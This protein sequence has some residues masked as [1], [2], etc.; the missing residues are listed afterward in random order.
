MIN[1]LQEK[2]QL[3]LLLLLGSVATLGILPFVVIRYL[4]GNTLASML[5]MMLI[6]GISALVAYAYRFKKIRIVSAIIALFINAGLLVV[7][8]AN[9]V[10]SFFWIYP[11]FAST[12][13]LVKPIEALSINIIASIVLMAFSDVFNSISL[14]S[15]I[16]TIVMLS[17]STFVYASH[18]EKQF[19]LLEALN[20]ID[21][22]TGALNRR[23][24][25]SDIKIALASAEHNGTEQFLAILDLDYFKAVNDTYGHAVGDQVLQDFVT[26]T[27]TNIRK[28]DRLYRLGGEE[29][30]LLVSTAKE[31]QQ[32]FID[33]L[34]TT[35]KKELKTPDGKEVTV[36]LGVAS[37]ASGTT[38]DTWLKRADDAL[39]LAKSEGRDRV[40][41]CDK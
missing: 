34:R 18:S 16:V 6:L 38:V 9:G 10:D 3:S 20:T 1:Q 41:Y 23:A 17:M 40:T 4:A 12:F 21:P 29:F 28:Y 32:A 7:V 33:N 27:T 19:R 2:Y 39:Y 15:Y 30:V 14:I 11:V 22:L 37:W 5:D 8:I 24:L 26:I 35:I 13:I 31:Q 25:N 36:S